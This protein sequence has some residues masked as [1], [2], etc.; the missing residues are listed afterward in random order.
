MFMLEVKKLGWTLMTSFTP[1][2]FPQGMVK[3]QLF[4][5]ENGI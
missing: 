3:I 1:C 4:R 2:S 5:Y